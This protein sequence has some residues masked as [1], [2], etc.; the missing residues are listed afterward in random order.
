MTEP[1]TA[2]IAL[3]A[4]L[5]ISLGLLAFA[6]CARRAPTTRSVIRAERK[7]IV[8][9]CKQVADESSVL[10]PDV[11]ERL[12]LAA[13]GDET[14]G[15][16]NPA[17]SRLRAAARDC[18][19]T[20]L[21]KMLFEPSGLS[22]D[23]VTRVIADVLDQLQ[24]NT[25]EPPSPGGQRIERDASRRLLEGAINR[26]ISTGNATQ[27]LAVF[28]DIVRNHNLDYSQLVETEDE[29]ELTFELEWT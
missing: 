9:R 22:S 28:L 8:R 16:G 5:A 26:H 17:Q 12:E 13:A 15:L 21:I 3:G 7:R 20:Q 11:L 10:T 25:A 1:I 2:Y 4:A 14:G 29:A 6:L 23:G 27:T 18:M 24:P 19:R